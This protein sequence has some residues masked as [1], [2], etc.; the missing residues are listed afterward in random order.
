MVPCLSR[1][2]RTLY[3]WLHQILPAKKFFDENKIGDAQKRGSQVYTFFDLNVFNFTEPVET[4][5][6]TEA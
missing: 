2:P 1:A 5:D 6:N 4:E 3:Q